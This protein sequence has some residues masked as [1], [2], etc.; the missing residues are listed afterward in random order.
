M[1]SRGDRLTR[2]AHGFG[3]EK[4]FVIQAPSTES[5][6]GGHV[7][8]LQLCECAVSAHYDASPRAQHPVVDV[9]NET[10]VVESL[11]TEFRR[12]GLT[13]DTA[14][15]FANFLGASA[16]AR[17]QSAQYF[18]RCWMEQSLSDLAKEP[19]PMDSNAE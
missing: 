15:E 1:T 12:C 7:S 17:H 9:D 5:D 6:L 10:E 18:L 3:F 2:W 16:Y 11:Y 13:E 14:L 4:S 8:D 19:A